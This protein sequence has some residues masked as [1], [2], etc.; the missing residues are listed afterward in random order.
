MF[1]RVIFIVVALSFFTSPSAQATEIRIKN[2]SQRDYENLEVNGKEF[3]LLK[4]GQITE[5]KSFDTAF[6][7]AGIS[8]KIEGKTYYMSP[9]D[10]V[11]EPMLGDGCFT[12]LIGLADP[13]RQNDFEGHDGSVSANKRSGEFMDF[14]GGLSIK[15]VEEKCPK[16]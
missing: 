12:Y 13:K 16:A 7:F 15:A 2:V 9:R 10:F 11:G 3:G 6:R 8:L 5:Y 1:C 14:R 4:S